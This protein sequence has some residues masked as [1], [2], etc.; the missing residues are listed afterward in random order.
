MPN[1]VHPFGD[2]KFKEAFELLSKCYQI[3]VET[4]ETWPGFEQI[5]AKL[6]SYKEKLPGAVQGLYQLNRKCGFKVINHGDFHIKNMMFRRHENKR[7]S[8]V[9][10]LDFQFPLINSPGLDVAYLMAIM[11]NEEVRDNRDE[12][13]RKYYDIFVKSLKTYGYDK[14][15]P[16]LVDLGHEILDCGAMGE[17]INNIRMSH[18]II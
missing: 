5:V 13:I 9:M 10:F 14:P 6:R 16:S 15:P 18:Q 17:I 3:L 7:I 1:V 12:I 11:G 4:A 2:D 8:D